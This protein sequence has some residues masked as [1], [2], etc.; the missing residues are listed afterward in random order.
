MNSQEVAQLI[1]PQLQQFQQQLGQPLTE[2]VSKQLRD[3]LPLGRDGP[4][5]MATRSGR[6]QNGDG[7]SDASVGGPGWPDWLMGAKQTLMSLPGHALSDLLGKPPAPAPIQHTKAKVPLYK[8]APATPPSRQQHYRDKLSTAAQQKPESTTHLMVSAV[9]APAQQGGYLH[10]AAAFY[11]SAFEG[12]QQQCR[13]ATPSGRRHT[14]GVRPG[15]GSAKLFSKGEGKMLSLRYKCRQQNNRRNP[16]Q[17]QQQQQ[18]QN[19]QF[20]QRSGSAHPQNRRSQS[21]S[22]RNGGKGKG[23]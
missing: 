7:L 12:I 2:Q 8:G 17:K 13:G 5:L 4:H 14:L 9:E 10:K 22:K 1:Q 21:P 20:Q 3:S 18:Q 23:K 15:D 19:Q 16:Q 6:R 11:P